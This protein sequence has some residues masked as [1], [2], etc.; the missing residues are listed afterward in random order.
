MGIC[1]EGNQTHAAELCVLRHAFVN[2]LRDFF[3]TFGTFDRPD[4]FFREILGNP[5]K[6]GNPSGRVENVGGVH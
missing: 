6:S 3:G 1:I 4:D 2:V 5:P